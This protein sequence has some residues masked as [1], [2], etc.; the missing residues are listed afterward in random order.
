[1]Y[2]LQKENTNLHLTECF[3]NFVARRAKKSNRNAGTFKKT[4][5]SNLSLSQVINFDHIYGCR[6]NRVYN[7]RA[8]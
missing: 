6:K 3:F 5:K 4:E 2:A 1:M 8:K 7:S